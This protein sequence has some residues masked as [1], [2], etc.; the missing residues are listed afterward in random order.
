M[1]LFEPIHIE[2]DGAEYEI[3]PDSVLRVLQALE[4]EG[5]SLAMLSRMRGE[6]QM[7]RLSKAYAIILRFAGCRGVSEVDVYQALMTGL[8]EE[9]EEVAARMSSAFGTLEAMFVPPSM[10]AKKKPAPKKKAT[11]KKARRKS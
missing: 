5:F 3:P 10:V 1:S 6:M 9:S 4:G 8:A 11:R 7:A 2:W